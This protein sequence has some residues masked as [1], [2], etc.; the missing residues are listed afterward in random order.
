MSLWQDFKDGLHTVAKKGTTTLLGFLGATTA[1]ELIFYCAFKGAILG[2]G[3]GSLIPVIGNIGGLVIGAVL[4]A[5]LA[6]IL[7]FVAYKGLIGIDKSLRKDNKSSFQLNDNPNEDLEHIKQIKDIKFNEIREFFNSKAANLY[8]INEIA[9]TSSEVKRLSAAESNIDQTIS[10]APAITRAMPSTFRPILSAPKPG[11]A[12]NQIHDVAVTDNVQPVAAE[13]NQENS[14]KKSFFQ[15]IQKIYGVIKTPFVKFKT[16]FKIAGGAAAIGSIVSCAYY[17]SM[18]G[19][20][21]GHAIPIPVVGPIIG[22]VSGGLLGA[23]IAGVLVF[24]VGKS[25]IKIDTALSEK[26]APEKPSIKSQLVELKKDLALIKQPFNDLKNNALR[27]VSISKN[28]INARKLNKTATD[29]NPQIEK[30]AP[31]IK[32]QPT[33]VL[34]TRVRSASASASNQDEISA[35]QNNTTNLPNNNSEETG[36]FAAIKRFYNYIKK[37]TLLLIGVPASAVTILSCAY[38]GALMGGAFGSAIP[39][40]GNLAGLIIGG[41]LGAAVAGGAI[42][43]AANGLIE[44][45][46][47]ITGQ[48]EHTLLMKELESTLDDLKKS[49]REIKQ[50]NHQLEENKRLL[51][52]LPEPAVIDND[53]SN[54]LDYSSM[55]LISTT[56]S[57][58]QPLI[59][60]KKND[61]PENTGIFTSIKNNVVKFIDKIKTPVLAFFGGTAGLITVGTCAYYGA[62]IGGSVGTVF[63]G[64]GNI[65]GMVVGGIFGAIIGFGFVTL[66]AKL[67]VAIHEKITHNKE[68]AVK[69]KLSEINKE[70]SNINENIARLNSNLTEMNEIWTDTFNERN[71][72]EYRSRLEGKNGLGTNNHERIFGN[73]TK[74]GLP[75]ATAS[76]PKPLSDSRMPPNATSYIQNSSSYS[77]SASV[78]FLPP[79]RIPPKPKDAPPL[80]PAIQNSAPEPPRNKIGN[81]D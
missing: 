52:G 10:S 19:G 27:L 7:L 80:P 76:I 41:I 21:L 47:I 43:L 1:A 12:K 75:S 54:P 3:L 73:K 31:P 48:D 13:D 57:D 18:I 63:P 32:N 77:S 40:L 15:I 4:G 39:G 37:P 68:D 81:K 11:I 71:T 28:L 66:T 65:I 61:E 23:V 72:E 53:R 14:N 74:P 62:M 59:E 2:S 22:Y 38:Y 5:G 9:N 46:K 35:Q 8:H 16:L 45:D 64:P 30:E 44:L 36:L 67:G 24:I 6:A 17:G 69:N 25:V 78:S 29:A 49:N 79:P 55:T 60:N 20:T 50:F 56:E 26:K 34:M 42:Y 70:Y 51:R 33:D 58:T